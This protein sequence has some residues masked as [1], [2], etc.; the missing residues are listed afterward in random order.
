M[1]MRCQELQ[2]KTWD[3]VNGL[4]TVH[5]CYNVVQTLTE[6]SG[7]SAQSAISP[8]PPLLRGDR[9]R[10]TATSATCFSAGLGSPAQQAAV[11]NL[12]WTIRGAA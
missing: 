4:G 7:N 12:L 2:R 8:K 1:L 11:F 5:D 3:D 10:S 6:G 9:N